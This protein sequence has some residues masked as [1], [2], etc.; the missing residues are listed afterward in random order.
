MYW[1]MTGMS[2][3]LLATGGSAWAVDGVVEIN[4]A[5]V[6]A[7]GI[8]PGD[9]PGFPATLSESGSYRLTGSLVVQGGGPAIKIDASRV[10]LDLGGF[11][12]R[13][14]PEGSCGAG[15]GIDGS[16][17]DNVRI[18]S[19][20]VRGFGNSGIFIDDGARVEN[21]NVRNNADAGVAVGV[22]SIIA[23][24]IASLN[25]SDGIN[26][27]INSTV[28]D[29]VARN[30]GDDGISVGSGSTVSD[31]STHSNDDDGFVAGPGSALANNSSYNNDEDGFDL[32]I[33]FGNDAA[34]GGLAIGN[35]AVGNDAFGL[36]MEATWG[37]RENVING[38][39]NGNANPQTSSGINLGSNVCGSN[40]VCP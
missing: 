28:R 29:S 5:R 32:G 36:R 23:G 33:E 26:A 39:N 35:S 38:N 34:N 17:A 12:L 24:V 16:L 7:G 9:T 40:T 4:A 25:G 11:E 13:C 22:G 19:G 20:T 10:T 27:G 3:V 30:N 37:F 2:L 15:H 21:V 14:S 8:T 1:K 18:S 6:A 31:C